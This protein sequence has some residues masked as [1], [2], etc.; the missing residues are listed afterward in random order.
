[1]FVFA[2]TTQDGLHFDALRGGLAILP[3]AV[4]FLAGSV[5]SPRLISRYGRGAMAAG[6]TV[7]ALGLAL[8]I[9]VMLTAWPYVTILELAGPLAL[10]GAGQSMLFTGPSGSRSPTSPAITPVS[11]AER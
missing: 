10:I 1:M 3:M 8:I 7:Q 4:L 9:T 11:A 2:L 5:A 6:G